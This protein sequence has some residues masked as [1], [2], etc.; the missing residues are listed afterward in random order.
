MYVGTVDGSLTN[1]PIM[2]VIYFLLQ[3]CIYN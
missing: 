2:I 1:S 3:N